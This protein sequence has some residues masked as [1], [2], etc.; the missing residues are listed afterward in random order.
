MHYG[1]LTSCDGVKQM[2]QKLLDAGANPRLLNAQ[3]AEAL[4]CA[5]GSG[6]I[7]VVDALLKVRKSGTCTL[8]AEVSHLLG[9]RMGRAV[10]GYLLHHVHEEELKEPG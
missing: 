5:A 7:E 3:G 8:W 4:A 2:V 10:L 1:F 9:Q 6:H